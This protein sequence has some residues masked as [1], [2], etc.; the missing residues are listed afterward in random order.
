MHQFG[1]C[2]FPFPDGLSGN[3]C[4]SV[5]R[6]KG[7][8]VVFIDSRLSEAQKKRTLKHELSHIVLNHFDIPYPGDGIEFEKGF[9]RS[10]AQEAEADQYAEQMTEME[11]SKLMEYAIDIRYAGEEDLRAALAQI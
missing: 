11:L 1:I 6:Q 8:I 7:H 5:M 4:G 2:Y 10:E 9:Y 3:L